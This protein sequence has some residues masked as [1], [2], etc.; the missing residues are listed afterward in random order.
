LL[1]L[2]CT[3]K[4]K[5]AQWM[6]PFYLYLLSDAA[7]RPAM[8]CDDVFAILTRGPFPSGD[9]HDRLV[10]VHLQLCLDC[11]RLAEALRPNDENRPEAVAPEDTVSLPGYWGGPLDAEIHP[12]LSLAKTAGKSQLQPKRTQSARKPQRQSI[13]LI[14]FAAAVILGIVVAAVV[15]TLIVGTELPPRNT[16]SRPV[17]NDG[18]GLHAPFANQAGRNDRSIACLRYAIDPDRLSI[19]RESG[20]SL[21]PL[22]RIASNC[23]AQCHIGG[24]QGI[25]MSR[26]A[27]IE[28]HQ[29]CAGCH[30]WIRP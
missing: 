26:I 3:G 1:K 4:Y 23:C 13:N 17:G 2:R 21:P 5:V 18:G 14:H 6:L 16:T 11:Q 22:T 12:I 9:R 24:D 28:L 15:R 20:R 25:A 19:D 27:Q 30:D 8:N 7:K 10:E 29:N